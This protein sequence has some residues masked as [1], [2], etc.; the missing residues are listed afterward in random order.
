MKLH[1]RTLPVQRASNAISSA[2][3]DLQVEHDLTD[4]EMLRAL[5]DHQQMIT[6]YLLREERHPGADD[7]K[8]D[9]ACNANCRHDQPGRPDRCSDCGRSARQLEPVY[10][11]VDGVNQITGWLGPTCWRRHLDKLREAAM[12]GQC[13]VFAVP[14]GGGS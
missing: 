8:A 9:E 14:L 3:L 11:D 12:G 7:I 13:M 4:I 2:L 1:P 6:K 5:I 10:E